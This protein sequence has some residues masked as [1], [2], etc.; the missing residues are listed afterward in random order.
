MRKRDKGLSPDELARKELIKDY[1]KKLPSYDSL[2][3]GALAREMMGQMLENALEGELEEQLGYSK[4][5][6]R[7][8]LTD[9]SRNGY[10]KKSLKGSSG[11]IDI[12]V[13]RDRD[14]EFEPQIIKKNQNSITQEFERKV[15]SLFAKG[16]TLSDIKYHVADMY[17]FDVSESSISRITDKILPVAKEWQDRPLEETYAVVFMDAI[18]YNVRSEGRIVK[19]AVYIAIGINM[20]GMKEVLGMWVGENESAKFWLLKMNELKNR[21]L[22]D[23]LIICVDGLTGFSNAISAVYPDTEIQQCIIHQIRNTTRYVSY[24]DI[25]EL[26][27]DLK[28]VYKA[29]TEDI[30]LF[31]LDNFEEKWKKK[32][33]QIAISWKSNWVN[34]STYFKYPQEIRTLIYTTNTIEGFNRQLRKTSKSRTI[35]PTDDSLFKLLYLTTMDITQKW[36]G[37]RRD[38]GIIYSQLQIFFEERLK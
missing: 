3:L 24:K 19:K 34:L 18:H 12:S 33:P 29:N 21:G 26:M 25:K 13:P 4:Y 10:S 8:K 2:D 22:N 37:R 5:D 15:T 17:D 23:I 35:F 6:Y 20:D 11:I 32:Y 30:A 9:N 1:L 36:T 7:N 28:K 38:W 16:M 27:I 14:N 31:E